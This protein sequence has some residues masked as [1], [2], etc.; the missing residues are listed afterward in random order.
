MKSGKRPDGGTRISYV[1]RELLELGSGLET[2]A[3]PDIVENIHKK[4]KITRPSASSMKGKEEL[5]KSRI[6]GKEERTRIKRKEI[7]GTSQ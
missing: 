5:E 3:T 7:S 2:R 4:G 6:H 1:F